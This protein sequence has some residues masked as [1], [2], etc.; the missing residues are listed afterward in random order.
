MYCKLYEN[1]NLKF[2]GSLKFALKI[3]VSY[4]CNLGRSMQLICRSFSADKDGSF[5]D[6]MLT[7]TPGES[8]ICNCRFTTR[9]DLD[10]AVN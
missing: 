3:A 6:Y 8:G 1:G 5:S 4:V 10:H 7:L 9:K 2:S